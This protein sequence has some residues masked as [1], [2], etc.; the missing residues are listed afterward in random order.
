MP[1]SNFLARGSLLTRGSCLSTEKNASH[2][3]E[4]CWRHLSLITLR[5][6]A[7]KSLIAGAFSQSVSAAG[8]GGSVPTA[9]RH[10]RGVREASPD[11]DLPQALGGG[12]A[13]PPSLP[14]PLCQLSWNNKPF[15]ASPRPPL[16]IHSACTDARR[17]L[18]CPIPEDVTCE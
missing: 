17:A 4:V 16:L 8:V 14:S 10:N 7:A 2:L 9:A 11:P 15:P 5:C 1:P 6:R 18:G 13:Q 12:G 3:H